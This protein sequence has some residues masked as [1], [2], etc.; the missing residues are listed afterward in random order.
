MEFSRQEY[1]SGLPCPPP[2]DLPTRGSNS[3][4][5]ASPVLQEDSLPGEPPGK[6][7]SH[8]GHQIMTHGD[9]RLEGGVKYPTESDGSIFIRVTVA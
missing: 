2:G 8:E 9:G 7:L 5:P 1:W 3:C 6:L 4:L